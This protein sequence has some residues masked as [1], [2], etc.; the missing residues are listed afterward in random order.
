VYPSYADNFAVNR[1]AIR[2]IGEKDPNWSAKNL[3]EK[4]F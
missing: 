4:G 3:K 1:D 2:N